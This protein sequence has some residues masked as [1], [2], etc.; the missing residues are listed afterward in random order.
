MGNHAFW[1]MTPCRLV[2]TCQ[3]TR[4]HAPPKTRLFINE[5]VK[6]S[7]LAITRMKTMQYLGQ[8]DTTIIIR[9]V[10]IGAT[11]IVTIS[12]RKNL[13]AVP[14]NYSRDSLK[15]TAKLG[16]SHI[17]RKVMQCEA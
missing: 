17:I 10:I 7:H 16:T 5:V 12:L 13:E 8:L 1:G 2:T 15:K 4:R 9:S 14:G 6:A 11:G 3:S